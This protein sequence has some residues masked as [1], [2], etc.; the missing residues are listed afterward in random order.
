MENIS[1][2]FFLSTIFTVSFTHCATYIRSVIVSW[3]VRKRERKRHQFYVIELPFFLTFNRSSSVVLI[4]FHSFYWFYRQFFFFRR[5]FLYPVFCVVFFF[6]MS[7]HER[8]KERTHVLKTYRVNNWFHLL[9][10][11]DKFRK[12]IS[13]LFEYFLFFVHT[14][15]FAKF[16]FYLSHTVDS[17]MNNTN[18]C[19]REREREWVKKKSNKLPWNIIQPISKDSVFLW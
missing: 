6:S 7:S 1:E 15:L 17:L 19:L 9:F 11:K 4:F 12:L 5:L 14:F 3:K 13:F 8:M 10:L 18:N 2:L 16:L